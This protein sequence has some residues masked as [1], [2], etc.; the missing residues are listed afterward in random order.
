MSLPDYNTTLTILWDNLEST[1]DTDQ[2]CVY[3]N[4]VRIQL[5]V[6]SAKIFKF[7]VGINES[8]VIIRHGQIS[9]LSVKK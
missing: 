6:E 5:K 9:Q 4:S 7:L 2:P 8:Y 3:G 1:D